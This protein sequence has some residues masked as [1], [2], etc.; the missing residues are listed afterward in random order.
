MTI[1]KKL[2][3][4]NA[5]ENEEETCRKESHLLKSFDNTRGG[6]TSLKDNFDNDNDAEVD[7]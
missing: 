7:D 1:N 5:K 4:D 2:M 3:D 6:E